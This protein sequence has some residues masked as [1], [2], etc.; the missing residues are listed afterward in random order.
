MC[1]PWQ[2]MGTKSSISYNLVGKI[3]ASVWEDLVMSTPA[4]EYTHFHS[5][6]FTILSSQPPIANQQKLT[7]QECTKPQPT[8]CEQQ[9]HCEAQSNTDPVSFNITH[10]VSHKL[11]SYLAAS[12]NCTPLYNIVTPSQEV[13]IICRVRNCRRKFN[14][15]DPLCESAYYHK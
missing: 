1:R 2:L 9:H 11:A 14:L 6:T 3:I 15:I 8:S 12:Q 13:H 10:N 7:L 4:V 5:P